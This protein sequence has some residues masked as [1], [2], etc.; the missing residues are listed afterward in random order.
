MDADR[1]ADRDIDALIAHDSSKLTLTRNLK[2]TENGVPLKLGDRP[3]AMTPNVGQDGIL[4]PVD[5]RPGRLPPRSRR[6]LTTGRRLP[7]CPT[8]RRSRNQERGARISRQ[9]PQSGRRPYSSGTNAAA[10]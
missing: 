6:R 5:N 9:R 1:F 3:G 7:T 4:R 10:A 8:A 2:M